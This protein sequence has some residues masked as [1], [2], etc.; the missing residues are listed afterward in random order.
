MIMNFSWIIINI[1]YSPCITCTCICL[2]HTVWG[3][4]GKYWNRCTHSFWR[5]DIEITLSDGSSICKLFV[6]TDSDSSH[7]I[8]EKLL[9]WLKTNKQA[10]RQILTV[11]YIFSLVT[12]PVYTPRLCVFPR[13]TH[14]I[15][16][17][18]AAILRLF[19]ISE[20]SSNYTKHL[21][22]WYV[23]MCIY[24]FVCDMVQ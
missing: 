11:L 7:Q 17:K 21:Q 16:E 19:L 2:K 14:T 9:V 24:Q 8:A 6:F 13:M 12:I 15:F 20:Q 22:H 4:G 23:Q 10:N 1:Q 18:V 5:W 3:V